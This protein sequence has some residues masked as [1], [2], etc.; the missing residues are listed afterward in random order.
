AYLERGKPVM[1]IRRRRILLLRNEFLKIL[2]LLRRAGEEESQVIQSLVCGHYTELV[3]AARPGGKMIAQRLD[4]GEID[5]RR[6]PVV[7]L[8]PCVL[9]CRGESNQKES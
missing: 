2:L 9:K 1:V 4:I 7:N 3:R 8:G 5:T 6:Y